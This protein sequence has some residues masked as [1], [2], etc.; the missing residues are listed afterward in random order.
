MACALKTRN[1]FVTL[2]SLEAPRESFRVGVN[3]P[4]ISVEKGNA[5]MGAIS[6]HMLAT[7]IQ[8]AVMQVKL[9]LG[10]D[11]GGDS[12]H[13]QSGGSGGRGMNRRQSVLM[14]ESMV[15]LTRG[16]SEQLV[17]LLLSEGNLGAGNIGPAVS[18]PKRAIS[19]DEAP[20]ERG[21]PLAPRPPAPVSAN[22]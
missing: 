1:S 5:M 16:K 12:G 20:G 7:G 3:C 2:R 18:G 21:A 19:P 13:H 15:G 10:G 14:V 17:D 9:H 6:A 22:E 11:M 4:A 8:P